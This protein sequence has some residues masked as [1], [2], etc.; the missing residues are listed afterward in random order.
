MLFPVSAKFMRIRLKANGQRL[1]GYEWWHYGHHYQLMIPFRH[2]NLRS[3]FKID[4]SPTVLV[5]FSPYWRGATKPLM[6]MKIEDAAS[7][8]D[9]RDTWFL[10]DYPIFKRW[11]HDDARICASDILVTS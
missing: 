9:G 4:N 7:I 6:V 10:H 11:E 8:K 5:D 2:V 3:T 1:A